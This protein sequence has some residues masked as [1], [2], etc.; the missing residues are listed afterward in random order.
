M[1][2][3]YPMPCQGASSSGMAGR[4][5]RSNRDGRRHT[6]ESDQFERLWDTLM[7]HPWR[8]T[9][10]VTDLFDWIAIRLR[11]LLH[12]TQSCPTTLGELQQTL[13]LTPRHNPAII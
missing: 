8:L 11:E 3:S 4:Y 10:G 13:T 12:P 1:W 9:K 6:D 5:M 7:N 2:R